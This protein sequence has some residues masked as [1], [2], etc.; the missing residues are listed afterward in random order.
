M[1]VGIFYSKKQKMEKT[2]YYYDSETLSFKKIKRAKWRKIKVVSLFLVASMLFGILFV[3]ILYNMEF[4]Y[5]PREMKQKREIKEY[6]TQY[7]ILN[8]K[9][10]QL[11]EVLAHISERDNN[12]YR[13][14]FELSPISDE[15]RKSGFGGVNRYEYL[16]NFNNSKLLINTTKRMDIIQKQ[17]AI[18]SKSLDE[19]ATI[20]KERERLLSS[21]PAIQPVQNKHLTRMASGYGWRNDPFTK[22]RKFHY[23]MDFTA[24]TGTPV[25]ASGDGVVTRADNA[26]A[27]YG[28]H[29]R[30][31][32]GFGYESLYAHL[33]K[34]NV[35]VGQKVKRGEV[36]GYVGSTGRSEA[37][38]LHYEIRKDGVH[39]NPINF[40]YASL[41]TE[42]Y[43]EML[44]QSNQENQA[45]D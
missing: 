36:I 34:Y 23:G 18:Q 1:S 40:Y 28:E 4:M 26:S 21:V 41:N 7:A 33:S 39:M 14:Y 9:M 44:R 8:K 42:E 27:G 2:K 45:L 16:E 6:Q 3:I 17:L 13:A 38:H 24:P 15:Q 31:D 37:P 25:Y 22:V 20:A 5:T 35:R 19:I 12:L 10:E 32:H 11:E 30:I 29:I 43:A